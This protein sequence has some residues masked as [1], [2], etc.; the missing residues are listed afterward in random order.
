MKGYTIENSID[1]LE[2]DV[3]ALKEGGGGGGAS[4]WNQLQ[5]KPF[6]TLGEELYNLDGA[7][8]VNV[9]SADKIALPDSTE[10]SWDYLSQAI[11]ALAEDVNHFSDDISEIHTDITNLNNKD[12]YSTDE[13]IIGTFLDQTHYRK[14]FNNLNINIA[15]DAWTNTNCVIPNCD[16]ITRVWMIFDDKKAAEA[17]EYRYFN[18]NFQFQSLGMSLNRNVNI[19]IIEYT[20][21]S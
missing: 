9:I 4:T 14:V 7:L 17:F 10:H 19:I 12:D 11:E 13:T 3:K 18:N 15:K 21:T 16:L 8:T 5:G 20:K 1:L 6:S 2:K